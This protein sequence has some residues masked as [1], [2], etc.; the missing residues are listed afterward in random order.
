MKRIIIGIDPGSASGGMAWFEEDELKTLRFKEC[1]EKELS[2]WF[3]EFTF[4]DPL[5]AAIIEKVHTFPGQGISSAGKFMENFGMLKGFLMALDIPFQEVS[6]QKWM[7]YYGMKRDKTEN[8]TE[9]KKR[10]RQK[11][12]ELYP[13]T[14]IVSETA[15][16]VLIARY[17]KEVLE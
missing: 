12:Q 13:K 14:K 11:A 17:A 9:W 1:T 5:V 10:L 2:N 3:K 4:N 6:P 8:K 16:A 15:D 7:S